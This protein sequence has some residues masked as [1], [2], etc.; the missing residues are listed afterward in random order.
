VS[1]VPIAIANIPFNIT[2]TLRRTQVATVAQF[3]INCALSNYTGS[4]LIAT[5]EISTTLSHGANMSRLEA[6]ALNPCG[7]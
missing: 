6:L 5:V 4:Q 7:S 3:N 1:A 2:V